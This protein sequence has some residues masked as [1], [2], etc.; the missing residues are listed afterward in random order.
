[1]FQYAAGLA[2]AEQH[3]TVLKLDVSWFRDDPEY[4]AHNRYA[5]SCFNITEQFATRD[6]VEQL[7]CK[8][9]TR[10]EKLSA[11][12]AR[13]F[14]FYHYADSFEKFGNLFY[15]RYFKYDPEFTAQPNFTYLHGN[16][17]SEKYFTSI[18]DLLKLHFSFRY[19]APKTVQ[20][21]EQEIHRSATPAFI[22]FRRGDYL[23]NPDFNKSMGVLSL[24]YYH[25]AV[26]ELKVSHPDIH[27]YI[28]SDDIDAVEQEFHIKAP[29]TFVRATQ[30]WHS[31]DK[32]RL[33]CQCHHGIVANSTFSWWA[34]WLMN[35]PE[36]L[37][38]APKQW[39][40]TDE[41]DCR[42]A[43]PEYWRRI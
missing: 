13:T 8:P 21:V 20:A 16:W 9:F 35:H 17:Q 29:H 31:Y 4:E 32:I 1:M 7:S 41:R 25:Q 5:L 24:E 40:R 42:D 43:V 12:I 27:F 6:E 39:H 38:Y 36:K 34:A 23:S 18:P 28:F 14:H 10:I 22:H 26:E 11:Q 33:M 19:P 37:I 3:R 2:L 15:D 30:P